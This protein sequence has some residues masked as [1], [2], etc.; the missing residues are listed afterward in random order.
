MKF[1]RVTIKVVLSLLLIAVI[2]LGAYYWIKNTEKK[3]LTDADRT[4]TTGQYIKLSQGTTH[5][6]LAGADTGKVVILIHGFSVPYFIWDGTFEYLVAQGFR[7]LRYDEF[8]RGFSDRPNLMYDKTLYMTQLKELIE[9]LKLKGPVSVAGISFGGKVARDFT[10]LYPALVDKVIL[11]DPVYE[12]S[13]PANPELATRYIF[14]VT[15]EKRANGQLEDFKY[16]QSHPNWVNQY[17]VQMQYKG[18]DHALVSTIYHYPA[19]GRAE[20]ISLN[21]TKKQV[22]LIWGREDKAVPFQYSD[23]IRSVLKT[24][25]L[26]VD[27]AAHLPHLE[28]PA[29]VN[30]AIVDFLRMP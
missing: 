19:A 21:E 22:L 6:E 28:K 5:Y 10:C 2:G 23:S 12:R 4:G 29:I 1:V 14:A 13:V 24:S 3:E 27:D 17:K 18:F 30:K 15:P 9:K 7:V 11:V 20:S 8:G 26:A 16:P 25:F